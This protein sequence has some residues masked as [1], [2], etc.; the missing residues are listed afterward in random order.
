MVAKRATTSGTNPTTIGL[1]FFWMDIVLLPIVRAA[2]PSVWIGGKQIGRGV[3]ASVKATRQPS[4]AAPQTTYLISSNP[5]R[6]Y[7]THTMGQEA[8]A[9]TPTAAAVAADDKAKKTAHLVLDTGALIKGQGYRLAT[10]A[11]RFWTVPE[12]IAEVRD[13][14]SRCVE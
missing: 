5:C 13:P 12:V 8:E 9:P 4:I 14:K 11:E 3:Y 2:P 1:G 7:T 6:R 10:M